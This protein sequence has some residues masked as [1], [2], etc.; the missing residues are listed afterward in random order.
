MGEALIYTLIPKITAEV[1]AVGKDHENREQHYKFRSIDDVY[2]AVNELL[3]KYQV[4]IF[5]RYNV[6]KDEIV[7]TAKG[8]QYNIVV[9]EGTYK[10]TAPDGSFEETVTFG[11]AID[12]GDKAFNKAMSQAFKYALF[13]VFCIPTEEEKD[14]EFESPTLESPKTPLKSNLSSGNDN[15]PTSQNKPVKNDSGQPS[16]LEKR[17][18]AIFFY[19]CGGKEGQ[20][21]MGK[22]EYKAMVE[23]WAKERHIS[24]AYGKKWT[25]KDIEWLEARIEEDKELPF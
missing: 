6:I 1:E 3:G 20:R 5:P 13:Q 16:E 22:E 19:W 25:E 17:A 10:F 2:N 15:I 9:L 11:E 7:T 12:Y 14:T 8:S 4:S 21:H 23:E 24:T 18:A